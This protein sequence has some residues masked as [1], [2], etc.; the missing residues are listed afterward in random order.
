MRGKLNL[1]IASLILAAIIFPV[2]ADNPPQAKV[3]CMLGCY[4]VNINK[5]AGGYEIYADKGSE[6][7]L[8]GITSRDD[9]GVV[10]CVWTRDGIKVSDSAEYAFEIIGDVT[11]VLT[12]TDSEYQSDSITVNIHLKSSC[13]PDWKRGYEKIHLKDSGKDREEF[14]VGDVFILKVRY[15]GDC[16]S[17]KFHWETDSDNIII[18]NPSLAETKIEIREGAEAGKHFVRAV[19]SNNFDDKKE[20]E[21]EIKVVDNTPPMIEVDY[22]NPISHDILYIDCSESKSG[23]SGNEND[24]RI[25]R[26]SAIL[27]DKQ[28]VTI[29]SDSRTI[30]KDDDIPL[31]EVE[32]EEAG[33]HFLKVIVED[34]HGAISMTIREIL[35]TE[36]DSK[37][38][39]LMIFVKDVIYCTAGEECKIDA[40]QTHSRYDG[41]SFG[42]F[43]VTYG[44]SDYCLTGKYGYCCTGPVC[45]HV[46]SNSGK[47]EIKIEATKGER[48]GSKIITV[49]VGSN[50]TAPTSTLTPIST[51]A[52][53]TCVSIYRYVPGISQTPT[54]ETPGMGFGLTI[55]TIIIVAFVI[56]IKNKY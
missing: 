45:T 55:T 41:A 29:D 7:T 51:G 13:L 53:P 42:F 31:L 32:T 17:Y 49:I 23:S 43:D 2:A 46:F 54:P 21:I 25:Y 28:N 50:K 15:S 34:S 22:E 30:R 26:C 12:V 20:K 56:R 3:T 39:P 10:S 36:G 4:E 52:Q 40:Y 8:S 48:S 35:V 37:D 14:S 5:V 33:L 44:D 24:D 27:S 1:L 9:Y 16:D 18:M 38:D 19:L 11:Y 47:Y 6:I